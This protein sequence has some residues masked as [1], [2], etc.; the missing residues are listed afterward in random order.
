VAAD[1]ET[2]AV[3]VMLELVV[4]V[5]E[6]VASVVVVDVRFDDELTVKVTGLEVLEA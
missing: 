1:G 5:A 4:G 6:E 2:V 3:N